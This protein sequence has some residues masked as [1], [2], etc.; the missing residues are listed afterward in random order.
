MYVSI[1]AS[2]VHTA[3]LLMDRIVDHRNMG[4]SCRKSIGD[5]IPVS[6]RCPF[7]C[8]TRGRRGGSWIWSGVPWGV[9]PPNV[10]I[11]VTVARIWEGRCHSEGPISPFGSTPGRPNSEEPL[12][13]PQTG[14]TSP[15]VARNSVSLL[16]TVAR[17][18]CLGFVRY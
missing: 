15:F 9:T 5:Y 3:G 17:T 8:R 14:L 7:V 1:I 4:E 6:A 10:K 2:F 13:Q 12:K 11:V 16:T 18:V